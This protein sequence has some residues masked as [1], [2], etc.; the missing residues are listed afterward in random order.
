MFGRMV[1]AAVTLAVLSGPALG[2]DWATKMFETTTHDFGT[3]ARGEQAE[4]EFVLENLYVQ[5]VHVASVR[6]SCTCTIPQVKT[7]TLKA[8][9]KG[10]IVAKY[11][12]A[13][14]LGPR[15]ATLTVTFDKPFFAEVQLQVRGFIRGDVTLEPGRADFGSVEQGTGAEKIVTVRHVGRDDWRITEI[16][17]ANPQLSAKAKELSRDAGEVTYQIIAR[18]DPHAP[19]GDLTGILTLLTS[20][21]ESPEVQVPVDGA[22]QD[23]ISVSPAF[24]FLGIVEPGQSTTRPI[25]IRSREPFRVTKVTCDGP[26]FSVAA[27][28]GATEK[29]LHLLP[30]SFVAPKDSGRVEATISIQTSRGAVTPVSPASTSR[31]TEHGTSRR[32]DKAEFIRGQANDFGLL[33]T[34]H[35][36]TYDNIDDDG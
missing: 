24:L 33:K 4:Y 25:V 32:L 29:S 19:A 26:G 14:F 15:Q 23:R 10:A 30:V 28:D 20:D 27:P 3:V 13:A 5:D 11:N 1:R 22:V 2:Q 34:F 21:P 35:R 8:H 16:R 31:R 9:V 36:N 6:A 7:E 17:S 18:V 12:T